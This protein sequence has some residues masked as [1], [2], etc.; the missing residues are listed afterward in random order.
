MIRLLILLALPFS[1][2]AEMESFYVG[3]QL[4]HQL[5]VCFSKQSAVAVADA[6]IKG[7]FNAAMDTFNSAADCS[8]LPVFGASVGLVV[9]SGKVA[10][11]DKQATVSVVEIMSEGKVAAYFLTNAPVLARLEVVPKRGS[12]S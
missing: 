9:H 1:A 6:D 2:L 12:N 8:M 11:G 5:A 10:R 4:R 3:E 7:G